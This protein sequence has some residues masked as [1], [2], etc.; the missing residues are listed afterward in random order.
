M[1]R[2]DIEFRQEVKKLAKT[3][4]ELIDSF[5]EHKRWSRQKEKNLVRDL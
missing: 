2:I 4:I 3:D 1:Q 5:F